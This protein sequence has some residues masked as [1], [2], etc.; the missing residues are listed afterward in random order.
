MKIMA[1]TRVIKVVLGG[2]IVMAILI[3]QSCDAAKILVI[4]TASEPNASVT[5]YYSKEYFARQGVEYENEKAILRIPAT[6]T[7][8]VRDTVLYYCIQFDL[9][10]EYDIL[11]LYIE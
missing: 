8:M 2:I 3:L 7:P 5:I 11:F 9:T 10:S 6:D 4:K 1:R